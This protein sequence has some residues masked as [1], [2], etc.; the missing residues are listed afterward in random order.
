MAVFPWSRRSTQQLGDTWIP[1]A[2]IRLR[3]AEG[4]FQSFV[5][6]VDSGAVISLLRRSVADIL[7]LNLE[8][9]KFIDL[10]AVGGSRTRAFVHIVPTRIG[11]GIELSLPYAIAES[12]RVPNLLGRMGL[13]DTL[14]ID[15]DG[16]MRETRFSA[17]WLDDRSRRIW[18]AVLELSRRIERNW[19]ESDVP[20]PGRE[21]AAH[22]FTRASRILASIA[23]LLKLHRTIEAPTLLRSLFDASV[24][25]EYLMRDLQSR[26]QQYIEFRRI[27]RREQARAVVANPAGPLAKLLANSPLRAAEEPRVEA[28]FQAVQHRYRRGR[29]LWDRWYC[30]TFRDL[31]SNVGREGEYR[32]L[33]SFLCNW[34]HSDPIQLGANSVMPP[35]SLFILSTMYFARVA[36]GLVEESKMV[37]TS[38]E[39]AFLLEL[40]KSFS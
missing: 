38:D 34:V 29:G 2:E 6:Q 27:S 12:E 40:L 32:W 18:D 37:L 10:G 31:C 3:M 13:F 16:T 24:Q 14:Q 4:D 23:G 20:S 33:Q 7:G 19:P 8:E 11:D 30:M 25:C 9:G 1:N 15:F 5:V 21:A 39:H 17:P 28:E 26:A 22:L 35:D 36:W